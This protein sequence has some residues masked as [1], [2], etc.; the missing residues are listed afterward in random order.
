[1]PDAVSVTQERH[2]VEVEVRQ[3]HFV[4]LGVRI[5]HA[6][7]FSCYTPAAESPGRFSVL[8]IFQVAFKYY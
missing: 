8:F 5:F 4:M 1:M 7:E 2:L 6:K 3:G